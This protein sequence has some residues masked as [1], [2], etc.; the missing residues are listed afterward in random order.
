MLG[1]QYSNALASLH[2]MHMK[3]V[4]ATDLRIDRIKRALRKLAIIEGTPKW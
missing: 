3:S 1:Y 4:F 2:V